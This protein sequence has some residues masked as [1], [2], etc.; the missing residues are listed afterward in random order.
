MGIRINHDALPVGT[1]VVTVGTI[2]VVVPVNVNNPCAPCDDIIQAE[3][4]V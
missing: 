2:D 1:G 4:D 3:V